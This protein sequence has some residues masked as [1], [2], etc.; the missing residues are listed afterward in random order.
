MMM[1]PSGSCVTV[2]TIAP[3][4]GLEAILS[5]E[6]GRRCAGWT[7][8]KVPTR[9]GTSMWYP[10]LGANALALDVDVVAGPV[11]VEDPLPRVP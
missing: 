5:E 2:A 1:L 11:C 4:R 10:E 6:G 9:T 3:M 8:S 7:L